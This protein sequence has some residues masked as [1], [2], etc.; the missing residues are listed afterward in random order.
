[1][2]SLNK[3]RL[4]DGQELAISEWL[5][6]PLYS[7]IEFRGSDAV[8]L[9]AFSYSEGAVVPH[10]NALAARQATKSD[11]NMVRP[12]KINQDEAQVVFAITYEVFGL[13]SVVSQSP[14]GLVAPLPTVS[15]NALRSLQSALV[16][17][18]KVGANIKKPQ[19]GVPFAFIGQGVGPTM[20]AS[21]DLTNLHTATGGCPT[22]R[23]QRQLNLPVY[24]GGFGENAK[25][26][27][28]MAFFLR[29]RSPSGPPLSAGDDIQQDF[30][31]RWYLDGLKK[32]PA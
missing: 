19:V 21:G 13:T 5:H 14:A 26:G 24:I 4:P 9:D 15:A 16:V 32:R 2:S 17:E 28:S 29:T 23:N 18:L 11:T 30:R 27:N 31:L 10:S 1:M 25:P 6:W 3:I 12:G 8:N 22:P 20:Y 7:T